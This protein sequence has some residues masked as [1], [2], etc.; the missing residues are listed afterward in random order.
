MFFSRSDRK[1]RFFTLILGHITVLGSPAFSMAALAR[2]SRMLK[3]FF[4]ADFHHK[5]NRFIS[6]IR[7]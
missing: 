6:L 3:I 5:E 7:A 2:Q 4:F 1:S